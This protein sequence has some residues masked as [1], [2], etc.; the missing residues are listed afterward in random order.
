RRFQPVYV[1]EPSLDDTIAILR[2]LKPRY[3]AHH[4]GVKIKDSAL[5]AAA[6]LSHRYIAD[7][8]LPDK[9][10]DLMDEAASRLAMELESVPTE[11]DEVQRR[12]TQLELADRQLAEETEEHA[13]ARREEIQQEMG[14]LKRKLADL[15]K[16]WELEKSGLGDVQQSRQRLVEVE[17]QYNQLA[18][19]IKE[20]QSSGVLVREEDYQK[21]YELDLQRKKL[22][23]Q[24]EGMEV[25][26]PETEQR[27]LLRR[28]VGPEEIA[29]VVSAWTGI[30]VS[31]MMETERAKLLVMEERIHQRVIGQDEAVTA[32]ANAVR[33]NRSGL[34]DPNRPIGSFIFLGPTGVGKT[35]LCK[36]L[37][38][39]MF[40]DENA[41]IRLDMSEFMERHTV[42]RLIGAPPGYV[43]YEEGGMLTEAV[44]RRPY[45]VIL[46]DEIEKAHRDVFN[47][48]LQVLDDGRLS[49]S[50]GHTVD[51]TNTIVVMTSNIG[52][53]LIQEITREGGSEEQMCEAVL[54]TLHT[55]FLP[56]FLNRIDEVLIFHPLQRDEIHRIVVLQIARLRKQLAE[57]G[58][59]L[60]V[61]EAA[62]DAIA[63]E[64]Y[65]P[66][67][68]ARPLK[69]VIQQRIQNPLAVEML[70]RDVAEGSRV[71]IDYADDDFTF[72]RVEG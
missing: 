16:Q 61:S 52:S 7:R 4:K 45:A 53:Q 3:E 26:K 25:E 10:I 29:E 63:R 66:T 20:R 40:D 19:S 71:K 68:G 59:E 42:S 31:R 65:D 22:A 41:M 39:V 58:V 28:E 30:P 33:R 44:R 70:K 64:G 27:R 9:A 34:Q 11:I 17:H 37:A 32:V 1:D 47:I 57:K 14:D 49:D 35:E 12:L 15:R 21:L 6:N 55:R 62:I 18:A 36:A 60:E 43:G 13:V 23:E 2:G 51:F 56:E 5:V 50:H 48:L 24:I 67:F 72:E 8:F 46:L 54:A 38:E 69:R